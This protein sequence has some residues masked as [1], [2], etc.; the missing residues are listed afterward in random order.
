MHKIRFEPLLAASALGILALASP[1]RAE[2]THGMPVPNLNAVLRLEPDFF[3][4][5]REQFELEIEHL[6][7]RQLEARTPVLTVDKAKL[8]PELLEE[9]EGQSGDP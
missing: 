9:F 2:V 1:L 3:G 4:Q 7:R 5:G 8:K 6:L